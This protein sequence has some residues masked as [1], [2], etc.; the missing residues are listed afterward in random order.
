MTLPFRI[1]QQQTTPSRPGKAPRPVWVTVGRTDGY[2]AALRARGGRW[3]RGAFSFWEEP[4]LSGI[5]EERL[6]VAEQHEYQQ[7]RAA[8]RAERLDG[9][10]E[11]RAAAAAS[12]ERRAREMASIIPLGQPILIGHHSERGD[13]NYRNRIHRTFVKAAG[14]ADEASALARRADVAEA[15]A[16][17][18][19]ETPGYIMRRIEEAEAE[20]R[21]AWNADARTRAEER[22]AYWRSRLDAIGGQPFG[23]HNVNRGD[24]VQ[25]IGGWYRVL[26]VNTKTVKVEDF[27]HGSGKAYPR[28]ITWDHV[29]GHK[30]AETPPPPKEKVAAHQYVTYRGG[31]PRMFEAKTK[32]AAG[33]LA[34]AAGVPAHLLGHAFTCPC[35]LS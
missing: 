19:R 1:E 18:A 3:Y 7:E 28:L 10:A 4:D 20:A 34:E 24:L 14:L 29:K 6:S 23:K 9:A 31:M 32:K 22:A 2:E 12:A 21:T 30:P 5:E 16:T 15:T 17:G 25:W 33:E 35:K 8:V 13:R 26:A 27:Y 11:R